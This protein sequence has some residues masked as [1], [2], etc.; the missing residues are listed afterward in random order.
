MGLEGVV[1][2]DDVALR[3]PT[4]AVGAW[5]FALG[6]ARPRFCPF[7][8]DSPRVDV[9]DRQLVGRGV[10]DVAVESGPARARPTR[11]AGPREPGGVVGAG[12]CDCVALGVAC[13][14]GSG[15]TLTPALPRRAREQ[16]DVP[17]R[18]RRHER[19]QRMIRREHCRDSDDGVFGAAARRQ[20]ADPETRAA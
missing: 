17:D 13:R 18:H 16:G 8:G 15:D 3:P 11:S 12:R 9:D 19:P 5:F 2:G 4:S 10:D 1:R 14:R 6:A 7:G 20:Q